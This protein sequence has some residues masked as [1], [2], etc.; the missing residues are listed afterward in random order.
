MIG[1]FAGTFDPFTL[2]HKEVVEKALGMFSEIHIVIAVNPEK[3]CMFSQDIREEII[4]QTFKNNQKIKVS[5]W[6]GLVVDYCSKVGASHIIRGLRGS[7]DFGYENNIYHTNRMINH[8]IE[9]VYFMSGAE[10]LGISSSAV[11]ELV[12]TKH[13]DEV[14]RFMA[15]LGISS[16]N[17]RQFLKV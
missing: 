9:T 11:R 10:A 3:K 7:I 16:I 8:E 13:W 2:G 15:P 17:Y 1:V 4:R 14:E 5:Y 12:K 6:E